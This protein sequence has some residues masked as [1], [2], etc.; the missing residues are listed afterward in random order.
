[1]AKLCNYFYILII[2]FCYFNVFKS[3]SHIKKFTKILPLATCFIACYLYFVLYSNYYISCASSK[4]YN[5]KY[6]F[7]YLFAP[8][9]NCCQ[10]VMPHYHAIHSFNNQHVVHKIAHL[11]IRNLTE[12]FPTDIYV[13]LIFLL[14]A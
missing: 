1:M 8:N 13:R 3:S 12:R 2:I 5:N 14:F 10:Q 4:T 7:W 6:Y 11:F 9:N